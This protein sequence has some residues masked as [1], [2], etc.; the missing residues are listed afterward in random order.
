MAERE[1]ISST[2]ELSEAGHRVRRA[3]RRGYILAR[4]RLDALLLILV[5]FNTFTILMLRLARLTRRWRERHLLRR[6]RVPML[7][8]ALEG[9]WTIGGLV[10]VDLD[11]FGFVR[12]AFEEIL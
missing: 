10:F 8:E 5:S 9:V 2:D 12:R 7:T 11:V 6:S 4:P 1:G 3:S